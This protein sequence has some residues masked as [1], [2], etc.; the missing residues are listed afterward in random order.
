MLLPREISDFASLGFSL[1]STGAQSQTCQSP[2]SKSY[3]MLCLKMFAWNMQIAIAK[4]MC[5][6]VSLLQKGVVHWLQDAAS[7][8]CCSSLIGWHWWVLIFIII[9]SNKS[10]LA[11]NHFLFPLYATWWQKFVY[12]ILSL[13]TSIFSEEEISTQHATQKI[14]WWHNVSNIWRRFTEVTIPKTRRFQTFRSWDVSRGS[15]QA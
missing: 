12:L 5:P 10:F 11:G 2:I 1:E 9:I 14:C 15:H 8:P 4:F 13:I 3:V 6:W 7:A